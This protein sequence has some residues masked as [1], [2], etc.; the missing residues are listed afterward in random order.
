MTDPAP[1]TTPLPP[2]PEQYDAV[3]NEHA[4][5]RGLQQPYIAGGDDPDLPQTVARERQYVRL[6]VAMTAGIIALGFVLGIIAA[7]I[8]GPS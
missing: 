2:D 3:R 7:L 5:K 4:R 6:L 1:A 8:T